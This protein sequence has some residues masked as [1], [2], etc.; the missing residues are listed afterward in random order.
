MQARE[1]QRLWIYFFR[2]LHL[3]LKVIFKWHN[4]WSVSATR[5][6]LRGY[7]FSFSQVYV[8][9]N[10]QRN[11]KAGIMEGSPEHWYSTENTKLVW[12]YAGKHIGQVLDDSIDKSK[13]LDILKNVNATSVFKER[14]GDCKENWRPISIFPV[15]TKIKK[16]KRLYEKIIIYNLQSFSQFC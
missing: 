6:V 9:R 5:D 14:H 3:S 13:L 8:W 15:I 16:K 10:Y 1:I 12:W 11:G 4:Y 2:T 7:S